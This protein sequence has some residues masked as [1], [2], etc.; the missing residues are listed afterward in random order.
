MSWILLSLAILFEVAATTAMKLSGG[1]SKLLPS[2][3]MILFY[4]F[5]F[6]LLNFALKG[7]EVSVAYAIWSGVGTALIVIIGLILFREKITTL[8]MIS[9][10]LIILGVIGLNLGGNL[11]EGQKAPQIESKMTEG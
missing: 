3:L 1:F 8:K 4:L 5:S 9:I 7:L 2:L 10:L 6:S 11:H